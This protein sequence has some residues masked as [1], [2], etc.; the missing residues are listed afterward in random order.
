MT[1]H[2]AAVVLLLHA[3]AGT[4]AA[5]QAPVL[6]E[7]DAHVRVIDEA[8]CEVSLALTVDLP[9]RLVVDHRLLLYPGTT[10]SD[11]AVSGEGVTRQAERTIGTTISLP[12]GIDAGQQRYQVSYRVV[13]PQAW[14]HR[15]PM[16]LP[17]IP[18]D[19]IGRSVRISASLPPGAELLPDTFPALILKSPGAAD[20]VLGHIPA[21]IRVLYAKP[22][23][24]VSWIDRFSRRR[25]VDVAAVVFV[26]AAFVV[27]L[28]R[29]AR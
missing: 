23:E 3:A 4:A 21:L 9:E 29:R 24:R 18:T 17:G 12:L 25:L 16:W 10:V 26:V 27:R 6:R 5:A 2:L 7:A 15:C 19:G 14:S 28:T 13:Q 11:V 1:I 22:G 8:T 20:V